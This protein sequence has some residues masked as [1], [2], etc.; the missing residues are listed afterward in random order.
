MYQ[1]RHQ[2]HIRNIQQG[3]SSG[4]LGCCC[5]VQGPKENASDLC[6]RVDCVNL[7]CSMCEACGWPVCLACV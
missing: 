5:F 2:E 7:V 1:G 6:K 3:S 4:V